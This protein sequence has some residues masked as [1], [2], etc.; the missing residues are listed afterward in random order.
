[1]ELVDST[2]NL[3]LT[4]HGEVLISS[5]G[6]QINEGI[7]IALHLCDTGSFLAHLSQR[8]K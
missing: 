1:M 3:L 7:I 4:V 5:E 6:M 2:E 8:L